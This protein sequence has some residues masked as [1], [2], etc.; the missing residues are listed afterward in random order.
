MVVSVE[1]RME[2]LTMGPRLVAL[3]GCVWEAGDAGLPDEESVAC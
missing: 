3:T 2:S 1:A